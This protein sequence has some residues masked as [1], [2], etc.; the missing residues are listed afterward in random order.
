MEL[1]EPDESGRREPLPIEGS[2]VEMEADTV[3]RVS[4]INALALYF[5]LSFILTMSVSSH[6][7]IT[8]IAP[9]SRAFSS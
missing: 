3:I 5:H 2:E 9:S 1:G 8:G 7:V 6:S 4:S